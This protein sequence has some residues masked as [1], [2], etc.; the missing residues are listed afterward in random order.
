M[1]QTEPTPAAALVSALTDRLARIDLTRAAELHPSVDDLVQRMLDSLPD[2]VISEPLLGPCYSTAA[3]AKW[4]QITRQAVTHQ[5]NVGTLFAVE[6]KG[7][8]HHPSAQFDNRGRQTR[9]FRELWSA[10]T[11][12][13]GHPLAFAV[14]L[15]TPDPD[16]G[17][18]PAT[19]LASEPD[20][21]TDGLVFLEDLT[22]VEPP[23]GATGA[24]E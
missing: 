12:T 1:S 8:F 4:K 24:G 6:H 7:K 18:T 21:L 13:G 2:E 9:S 22:I 11:A 10:F 23:T 16:T 3:L 20:R 14:W 15:Q 17:R 5:R 19:R